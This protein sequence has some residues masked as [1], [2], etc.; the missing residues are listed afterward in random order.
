MADEDCERL[1]ADSKQSQS[2]QRIEA[3]KPRCLPKQPVL[4][5]RVLG[6]R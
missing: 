2:R 5:R 4:L 1:S 3:Q 6:A